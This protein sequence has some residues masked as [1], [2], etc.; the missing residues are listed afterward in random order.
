MIQK[1]QDFAYSLGFVV[2]R[3][4]TLGSVLWDSPAFKAGLTL[5]VKLIAVD[6]IAY[7]ADRLR[8]AVTAAAK[9]GGKAIELLIK[10]GD[11]YRAVAID[12][13]GG[14]RYPHL[15]RTG[16]AAAALDAILQPKP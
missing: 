1:N 15:E 4:E 13:H 11:H 3:D 5:G 8:G 2:G 14:L 6:G 7:D 9:P 16:S 10:D 12:Y